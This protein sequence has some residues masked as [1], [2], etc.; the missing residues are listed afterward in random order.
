MHV[1]EAII[2]MHEAGFTLAA[3]GDALSVSPA[4][5]LTVQQRQFIR[6][7]KQD[8]LAALRSPGAVLG[9]CQPG[10]DIEPAN[11]ARVLVHV[12]ELT[13]ST[14]QRISCDMSVP[15]K[16]LPKLRHSLRFTL[17]DNGG[18][19]PLLGEPGKSEAE[20]REMLIEKYGSRLATINGE[21]VPVTC[22]SCRHA[23]IGLLQ[24]AVTC[25]V[26]ASK[27][28]GQWLADELHSCASF[29]P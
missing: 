16:N 17:K 29:E 10:N 9:A 8:I 21:P 11:D 13:L 1:A 12:L 19:G 7:N 28:P 4:D 14:G 26:E 20:L 25:G 2:K 3:N 24:S 15:A 27:P 23:T 6:E 18:G 22:R 5:Q